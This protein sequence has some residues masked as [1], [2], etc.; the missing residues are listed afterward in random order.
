MLIQSIQVSSL[1]QVKV[2]IVLLLLFFFGL[3][4]FFFERTFE[5]V[6]GLVWRHDGAEFAFVAGD[7]S[8]SLVDNYLEEIAVLPSTVALFDLLQELVEVWRLILGDAGRAK[9]NKAFEC[10]VVDVALD[11]ASNEAIDDY[12]HLLQG[13]LNPINLSIL[14]HL[15]E[16]VNGVDRADLLN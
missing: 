3:L 6:L 5:E 12:L 10:L 13:L 16:V 8:D 11:R 2:I 7:Q 15:F 1:E 14:N 4:G 9:S